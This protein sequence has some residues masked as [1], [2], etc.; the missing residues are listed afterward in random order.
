[1]TADTYTR[2]ASQNLRLPVSIQ[3]RRRRRQPR[4]RLIK[5]HRQTVLSRELGCSRRPELSRRCHSRLDW[6]AAPIDGARLARW[7]ADRVV[8][9]LNRRGGG[10][11]IGACSSCNPH[12]VFAQEQRVCGSGERS[13][14]ACELAMTSHTSSHVLTY[15]DSRSGSPNTAITTTA[16]RMPRTTVTRIHHI[17]QRSFLG[18]RGGLARLRGFRRVAMDCSIDAPAC[19][20]AEKPRSD[21]QLAAGA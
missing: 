12:R 19:E 16:A 6:Y 4:R 7:A 11:R 5:R 10:T 3:P 15:H 1:M 8:S 18:T 2:A 20:R 13:P 21:V 17:S 14:T 9:E